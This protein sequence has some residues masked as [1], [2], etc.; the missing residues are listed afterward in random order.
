M[1]LA[2]FILR[3]PSQAALV[4]TTCAMLAILLMPF[5]WF[6][7]AALILLV[8]H[9]D[10]EVAIR[11]TAIASLAIVVMS[12]V[13]FGSPL[14]A[15]GYLLFLWLPAGLIAYVLKQS[16]S[17][18][19]SLQ[20]LTVIGL[21]VITALYLFF[22]EMGEAWRQAFEQVLK[23]AIEQSTTQIDQ[24][25]L[26]NLLTMF[27]RS[28]SGLLAIVLVFNVLIGLFI[29]RWWQ[30]GLFNPGGF[31]RE[32]KELRLG[33]VFAAVT[34]F[35][36][37]ANALIVNDWILG[38]MLLMVSMTLLQGI[39]IMHGVVA[40]KQLSGHWLFGFYVLLI[41]IPQVMI[42]LTIMG[43]LDAWVDIRK[44]VSP[45]IKLM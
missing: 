7:A 10:K 12:W 14:L 30:A 3:G 27:A 5:S 22:P 6:S 4:M 9:Q 29:A 38:S 28:I 45:K 8:L 15:A 20:L 42:F 25:Q 23:P 17:L 13:I 16:V 40:K 11:A 24:A 44:Q 36:M 35:T 19:L 43:L 41:L 33:K 18:I 39:A 31:S 37:I 34:V 2:R 1:V 26:D 21:L 32:F